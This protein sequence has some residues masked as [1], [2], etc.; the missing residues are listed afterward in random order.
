MQ[1]VFEANGILPVHLNELSELTESTSQMP[2]GA[3]N[4]MDS[5]AEDL[6]TIWENE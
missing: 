1:N 3:K 2:Q 4:I 5:L 6:K